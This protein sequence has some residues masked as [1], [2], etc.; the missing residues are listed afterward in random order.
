VLARRATT[1]IISN[2]FPVA[3]RTQ[4]GSLCYTTPSRGRSGPRGTPVRKHFERSLDTPESNVAYELETA[5][6]VLGRK[7]WDGWLLTE[8]QR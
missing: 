5:L 2:V 1:P 4:A 6:C 7:F 8:D 3:N